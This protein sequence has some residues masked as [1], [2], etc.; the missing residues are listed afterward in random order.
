[1]VVKNEEQGGSVLIFL[2]IEWIADNE[3]GDRIFDPIVVEDA[4]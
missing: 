1:L 3:L 4:D 2:Q